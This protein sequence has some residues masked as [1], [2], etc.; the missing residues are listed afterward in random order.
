MYL[1]M[2]IYVYICIYMFVDAGHVAREGGAGVGAG[3][4]GNNRGQAAG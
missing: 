1:L 2:Y 3:S 4:L